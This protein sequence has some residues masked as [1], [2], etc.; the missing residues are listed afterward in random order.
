MENS[1]QIMKTMRNE[2]GYSMMQWLI[3]IIIG[4]TLYASYMVI[5]VF[6]TDYQ[7]KRGLTQMA[8]DMANDLDTQNVY[9]R[10]SKKI[11]VKLGIDLTQEQLK[12]NHDGKKLTVDIEYEVTV[13]FLLYGPHTFR[14]KHHAEAFARRL[15]D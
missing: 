14:F 6:V 7:L 12:L 15:M 2:R 10:M 13:D 9:K 11:Y 3:F 5:P 1:R 4:V 8:M